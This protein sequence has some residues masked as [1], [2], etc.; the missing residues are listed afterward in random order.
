MPVLPPTQTRATKQ[1]RLRTSSKTASRCKQ[2]LSP[3]TS[4]TVSLKLPCCAMIDCKVIPQELPVAVGLL[5]PYSIE[6]LLPRPTTS[7][8]SPSSPPPRSRL[9]A[10]APLARPTRCCCCCCCRS[11]TPRALASLHRRGI[12]RRWTY[13]TT[14]TLLTLAHRQAPRQSRTLLRSIAHTQPQIKSFKHPPQVVETLL[15]VLLLTA[16]QLLAESS[17]RPVLALAVNLHT[18]RSAA[19]RSV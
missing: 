11:I 4:R 5:S 3:S 12:A 15:P 7:L 6:E 19:T 8:P 2:S 17:G 13:R 9:G 18:T 10:V 14:A 1:V 16:G